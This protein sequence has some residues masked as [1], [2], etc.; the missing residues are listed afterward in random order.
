MEDIFKPESLSIKNLFGSPDSLFEVPVYQRPYSWESEEVEQLWDDLYESYKNQEKNHN[1]FLGSIITIPKN[2]GYQDIVDGQQRLTTLMILF[3]V[4]RDLYPNINHNIDINEDSKVIKI[5]RVKGFICD[6]DD[7][8]RLRLLTHASHQND[9]ERCVLKEGAANEILS[10]DNKGSIK[11]KFIQ[12]SKIFGEKL[13]EIGEEETGRMLNYIGNYVK[14]IKITCKGRSFA[15]KLFQV[16]NDRGK[17]LEAS[18]LIKS[19]L[20]SRLPDNKHKQFIADW[21]KVNNIIENF[22]CDTDIDDMFTLYVYYKLASNPKRNNYDEVESFSKNEDSNAV[23]N[24]FKN[25]CSLYGEHISNSNNKIINCFRYLRWKYHWKAILITALKSNFSEYKELTFELRRF[26]YLNWIAGKTVNTI[27]QTSFNLIKFIKE[28][29]P[30]SFIKEELNKKLEEGDIFQLVLSNLK[31]NVAKSSW[32]KPVLM[33]I[34]Y[35]QTDE[36]DKDFVS[37]YRKVHLEHVLPVQYRKISGWE[38]IEK[39]TADNYLHSIGNLTLLGGSKNVEASNN[40]FKVKLNV[41]KGAGKHNKSKKGVTSFQI[42][43]RIAQNVYERDIEKWN[44]QSIEDRWNWFLDELQTLLRIDASSIYV[45][46]LNKIEDIKNPYSEANGG[47]DTNGTVFIQDEDSIEAKKYT[48]EFHME[49]KTEF[50]KKTYQ[51]IRDSLSEFTFNCQRNYISIRHSKNFVYLNFRKKF[52]RLIVMLP[53]D[54]VKKIVTNYELQIPGISVQNFYNG[55]CTYI[56]IK[57]LNHIDEV[58]QVLRVTA[59]KMEKKSV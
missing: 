27:K 57:S 22:E 11:D 13:S 47:R 7:R 55:P 42:T 21:D 12:V 14:M 35:K 45:S 5:K 34:E 28:K 19:A 38:H 44:K 58:Y 8:T 41:Y 4:I 30:L 46:E 59:G 1:Y 26:Y 39:D 18:D 50:V 24:N 17:D 49:D 43:Q 33:M 3:C 54:E 52:I 10:K 6:A 53:E 25:F 16:L 36:E 2:N 32:I 51:K 15:V 20:I 40:S 9:F 29:R 31:S 48:E 23:I 37:L 56:L